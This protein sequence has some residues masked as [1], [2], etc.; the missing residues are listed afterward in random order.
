MFWVIFDT[1]TKRD[2]YRDV[3]NLLALPP[4]STI[5]YDYNERH[6]SAAAIEE[7]KKGDVSAKKVLV[8]YAQFK[9]FNKR[10]ADPV[11]H[12]P[13]EQGLWIATRIATLRHLQF[14]VNRYYFYLEMLEYPTGDDTAFEAIIQTLAAAKEIPFVKWVGISNLDAQFAALT[15]G[16]AS[17]NWASVLNRI[18]TFPSQFA[19]DSFWRIAKVASG[20][21]KLGIRSILR[22]LSEVSAGNE[23]ITAVEAVFPIFEL[24]RIALQIESRTPE[25][26]KEQRGKETGE[27]RAIAFETAAD[28]PLKDIN[29]KAHELR[30]Y[31]IDWIEAEVSGSDRIDSQH[32]NLKMKTTPPAGSYPVGPEF[33]LRF[34]VAKQPW[35]AY[36]ALLLGIVSAILLIVGVGLLEDYPA[37]GFVLVFAGVML[38]VVAFFLWSGRIRFPGEK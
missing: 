8:A 16:T 33:L 5:R 27:A 12:I 13:Y 7:A 19:G 18:G 36:V 15:K 10:D 1:S 17:D 37:L 32:C 26:D 35:R 4:G 21:Q 31:A 34:Q 20:P 23:T 25:A 30:R 24:D 2:Y 22:D 14:S 6:L 29:G 28:G 11:G 38:S 9:N 3:H